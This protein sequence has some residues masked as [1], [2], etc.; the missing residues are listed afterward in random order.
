MRLRAHEIAMTSVVVAGIAISCL[1]HA[2]G[3]QV[4]FQAGMIF[5]VRSETIRLSSERVVIHLG[6]PAHDGRV[7]CSYTVQN[8]SGVPQNF[9]MAFSPYGSISDSLDYKHLDFEVMSG[10][11]ELPVRFEKIAAA[12]WRS[13]V[14]T[15]A[16]S[17]PVWDLSIP[18]HDSV[19]VGMRYHAIWTGD[20][21]SWSFAYNARPASLWAGTISHAKIEFEFEAFTAALLRSALTG[22]DSAQAAARPAGWTWVGDNLVWT[23]NDW[24]P[25][26]DVSISVSLRGR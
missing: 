16:S 22:I 8:L 26:E 3:P 5:P 20:S 19:E 9:Q 13:I 17:L 1:C 11:Q 18:A 10:G 23:F 14:D 21:D 15:E 24:E 25:D 12:T 2:N 7:S 6:E 4:G